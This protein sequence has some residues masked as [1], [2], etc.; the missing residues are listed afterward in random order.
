M[1][2]KTRGIVFNAIRYQ[3][4]SLIVRCFTHSAGLKSYFIHNA[5]TSKSNFRSAYFQPLSLIE[6]EA[7]HK[8]K[9][10]LET[11]KE[12]KLAYPY[13]TVSIDVAKSTIALFVAEMLGNS[14]REEEVNTDLFAFLETALHWL[15][16]H[17]ETA[18][19]HLILLLEVTKFLGFYPARSTLSEPYFDLAEGV[20]TDQPSVTSLSD[21]QTQL[22]KR[23]IG[24]KF[25]DSKQ[26]FS[27]NERNELLKILIDY[28]ALHLDGFRRPKSLEVLREVFRQ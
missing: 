16:T 26:R 12:V 6:L 25:S 11:F 10:T 7:I 15:D 27:A 5:F 28:Y 13:Q 22:L 2:V 21:Q 24:L 17:A 14:I 4:K 19:F 20:F 9:G 3:E 18:N 1:Q 23:L 8:N